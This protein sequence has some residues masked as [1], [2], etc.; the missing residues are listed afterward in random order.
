MNQVKQHD[1]L[2]CGGIYLTSSGR[3]KSECNAILIDF[4]ECFPSGL[5]KS[6][7][8]DG[9]AEVSFCSIRLFPGKAIV[10][11]PAKKKP[12]SARRGQKRG[13]TWEAKEEWREESGSSHKHKNTYIH[14]IYVHGCCSRCEIDV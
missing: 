1:N 10:Q 7:A 4:R 8:D 13:A 11:F 9:G 3:S 14:T 12:Q 6:V 5:Q 2:C